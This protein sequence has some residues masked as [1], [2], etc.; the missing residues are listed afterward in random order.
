MDIRLSMAFQKDISLQMCKSAST[1]VFWENTPQ[2]SRKIA[3]K[4]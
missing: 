1:E 3:T 2:K 4:N